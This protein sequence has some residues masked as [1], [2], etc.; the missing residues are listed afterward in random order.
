ME[1]STQILCAARDRHVMRAL[2]FEMEKEES[3]AVEIVSSGSA[4]LRCACRCVPDVLVVDAVLPGLD[5]LG[6]VDEL[7]ERLG[8]RAP[9]VIGGT[10]MSMAEEGFRRRGAFGVLRTPWDVQELTRCVKRCMDARMRIDWQSVKRMEQHA[11]ALMK[12]MGMRPQLKGCRYLA[13]CAAVLACEGESCRMESKAL[14][15]AVAQ[16]FS[17]TEKNVERLIRHAVE[18]AMNENA[19]G[20]Y[21][22]F[23]NTIDPMRGKPTNAQAISALAERLRMF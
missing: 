23:G 1:G 10:M 17:T 7:Q 18:S 14:Y 2:R 11:Y 16:Q 6:V 21:T 13:W 12:V 9:Y 8:S 5:G 4:A 22:F 20:M 3:C 15:R 19:Q